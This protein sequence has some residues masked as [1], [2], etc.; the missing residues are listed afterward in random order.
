MV[1]QDLQVNKGNKEFRVFREIKETKVLQ[2]HKESMDRKEFQALQELMDPLDPRVLKAFRVLKV[3]LDPRVGQGIQVLQDP[4][5]IQAQ[6]DGLETQ[7]Q[8]VGRAI[9]GLQ[10]L[11]ETQD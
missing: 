5:P 11:R 10:E 8:P 6:Q 2:G 1:Q 3:P 7:V 4:L 9:Q